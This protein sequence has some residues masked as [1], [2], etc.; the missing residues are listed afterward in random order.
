MPNSFQVVYHNIDQSAA[1]SEKVAK[2]I[3]KLQRFSNDIIG[4][5][6][7]LNL[8]DVPLGELRWG[9][10]G[11]G[12]DVRAKI[13]H[14]QREFGAVEQRRGGDRIL[15][16]DL[17]PDAR[18]RADDRALAAVDAQV[19]FP[20]RD[21]GGDRALLELRR[22]GGER[23]VGGHGADRQQVA[24][25]AADGGKLQRAD[26]EIAFRRNRR[27]AQR[28]SG[29]G[30]LNSPITSTITKEAIS[31]AVESRC[32]ES[33]DSVSPISRPPSTPATATMRPPSAASSTVVF[34]VFLNM[35][36]LFLSEGRRRHEGGQK[37]KSSPRNDDFFF[38]AP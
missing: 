36:T 2:R 17:H 25:K 21:L 19:R 31:A 35:G 6:V 30:P 4:G 18:V 5:R 24:S 28:S 29:S 27:H 32:V 15:R 11:R 1:L 34:M 7:V 12:A 16:E 23:T 10:W 8:A 37:S 26:A 3:E 38:L 9:D 13:Q 22:A 14:R 20:D 33:T